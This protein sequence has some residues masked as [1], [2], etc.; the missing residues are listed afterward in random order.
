[1]LAR[2]C[3]EFD[4][5]VERAGNGAVTPES[6]TNARA[7]EGETISE[8]MDWDESLEESAEETSDHITGPRHTRAHD[9]SG[10]AG[11]ILSWTTTDGSVL[12]HVLQGPSTEWGVGIS[13]TL[14]QQAATNSSASSFADEHGLRKAGLTFQPSMVSGIG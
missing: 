2:G 13:P 7:R 5:N 8:T 12:S 1:M 6:D 4:D 3:A 14:A 11:R 9:M 10:R